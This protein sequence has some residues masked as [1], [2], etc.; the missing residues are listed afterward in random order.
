MNGGGFFTGW[1]A[2][3]HSSAARAADRWVPAFDAVTKST[4]ARISVFA[5]FETAAPQLPQDEEFS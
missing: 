2:G 3:I 4:I 1:E 5:S